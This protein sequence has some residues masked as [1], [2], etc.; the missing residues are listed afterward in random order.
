MNSAADY[1]NG[2]YYC[3]FNASEHYVRKNQNVSV[4]T[5]K[6]YFTI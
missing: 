5:I 4:F 2:K 3:T 1:V 6:G